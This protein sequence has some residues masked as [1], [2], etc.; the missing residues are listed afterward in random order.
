MK[1]SMI[2]DFQRPGFLD[3]LNKETLLLRDFEGS[4]LS[5]RTSLASQWQDF[6]DAEQQALVRLSCDAS[7]DCGDRARVCW[8]G[9]EVP[10]DL[11]HLLSTGIIEPA[12]DDPQASTAHFRIP[13][14]LRQYAVE[15]AAHLE[16]VA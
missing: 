1:L 14:V 16:R 2:P 5:L 9:S 6:T 10:A 7:L 3:S 8:E 12:A 13:W 15:A 4:G 11:M